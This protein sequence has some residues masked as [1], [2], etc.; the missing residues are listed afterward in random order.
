MV[1]A[2]TGRG[3]FQGFALGHGDAGQSQFQTLTRQDQVSHRSDFKAIKLLGE[4][5]QRRVAAFAHSLDDV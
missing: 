1:A 2:H 3:F 4:L 5:D